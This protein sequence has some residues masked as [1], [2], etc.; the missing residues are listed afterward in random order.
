MSSPFLMPLDSHIPRT[1]CQ[2]TR[3]AP[4]GACIVSGPGWD[5][6]C[7]GGTSTRWNNGPSRRTWT[8]SRRIA[9]W[10]QKV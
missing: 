3:K 10:L 5:D 6:L 7:R 8:N 4:R 2:Y 9:R 1:F